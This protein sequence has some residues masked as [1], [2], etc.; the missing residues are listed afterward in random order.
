LLNGDF[1]TIVD[2]VSGG[3]PKRAS[4]EVGARPQAKENLTAV[5]KKI[6]PRRVPGRR[7]KEG[8][9]IADSRRKTFDV[10]VTISDAETL[11]AQ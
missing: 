10:T 11:D 2:T 8:V 3:W 5:D 6:K 9:E 4:D 7:A 1:A